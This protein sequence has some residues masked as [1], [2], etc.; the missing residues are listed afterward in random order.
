[1]VLTADW[2][3]K[4]RESGNYIIGQYDLKGKW[5]ENVEMSIIN[6]WDINEV[7]PILIKVLGDRED[8]SEAGQREERYQGF[9]RCYKP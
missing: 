8:W 9:R 5:I 2:M 7:S 3:N 1:M 4:K 6:I